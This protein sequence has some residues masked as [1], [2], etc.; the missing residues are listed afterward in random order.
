MSATPIGTFN[1]KIQCQ[2]I[3]LTTAPPTSGPKA[4]ASPAMPL[5]APMNA[6]R[7]LA[8]T[9]AL[10]IVSVNGVTLAPP[11]PCAARAAM[12][13]PAAGA[14]AAAADEAAKQ[15]RPTAGIR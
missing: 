15:N 14:R 4:T 5:H 2:E 8:G 10:R 9:P 3:P 13:A 1:Q 6:P 7:R 11:T 12:S